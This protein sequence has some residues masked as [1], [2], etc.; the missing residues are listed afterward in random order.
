MQVQYNVY[1]AKFRTFWYA[2]CFLLTFALGTSVVCSYVSVLFIC[3]CLLCHL[4]QV[5]K[6]FFLFIWQA[7]GFKDWLPA[8][9][10]EYYWHILP[11]I[12]LLPVNWL[13]NILIKNSFLSISSI[14]IGVHSTRKFD[15]LM[16]AKCTIQ[17]FLWCACFQC[18][19]FYITTATSL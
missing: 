4:Y 3:W 6:L 7:F 2:S 8:L 12:F 10:I 5:S 11:V 17:K 1:A 19:L 14:S 16:L 15:S 18:L 9:S 13:L